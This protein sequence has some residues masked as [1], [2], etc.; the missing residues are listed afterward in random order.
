MITTPNRVS[1]EE[2]MS[3]AAIDVMLER[4]R[5]VDGEGYDVAHDD[6]HSR[7]EIALAAAAYAYAS[8][9]SRTER[10]WHKDFLYGVRR[11]FASL[12]NWLWPWEPRQFRHFGRRRSLV[13][14]AA[15][16]LAEIERLDRLPKEEGE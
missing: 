7:G 6:Q 15:L 5:Q 4:K 16:L 8:T 14:A 12:I 3:Q 1:A 13:V 2:A 11:G 10:D 9:L